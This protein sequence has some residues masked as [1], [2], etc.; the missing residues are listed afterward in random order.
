[1]GGVEVAVK[2]EDDCAIFY[3][4]GYI[5][6]LGGEKIEQRCADVL[7][8]GYRKFVV[9][10]ANSPI[11]NS[12]G[13]SFLIGMIDRINR[14]EGSVCFSNLTGNN[15]EVFEFMGLTR[16]APIFASEEEAVLYAREPQ[17]E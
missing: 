9:N 6:N 15:S 12:I 1:M 3:P 4:H 5:N 14:S 17:G 16:F 10:F 7:R 13:L 11:I 2:F 8:D